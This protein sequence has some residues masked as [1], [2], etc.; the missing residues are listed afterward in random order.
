M[1]SETSAFGLGP[2]KKPT[3]SHP[4]IAFGRHFGR[5]VHAFCRI[6][7]LVD[8]GILLDL[9]MKTRPLNTFT[10]EERQEHRVYRQMLQMQPR[11]EEELISR[12]LEEMH[13]L[14][15]LIQ[16]GCANARADDT[17][18]L[19]GAIVDW[20]APPGEELTPRLARN[21][22]ADRGFHHPRTGALL[23]PVDLDWSD[24]EIKSKLRNQEINTIGDQWPAFLFLD[25]A[26]DPEDP[27]VGLFRGHL[28]VMAYKY[29]F[30]SPSSVDKEPKATKSGN[31]RIHGM[32]QVTP[33][34]IAYV[35]AQVRFALSSTS[36]FS[37]TDRVLDSE[38]FYLSIL[39]LFDDVDERMEVNDLVGWWN[40]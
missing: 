35:A 30:T 18:G 1:A 7:S 10:F 17:K 33:A 6:R 34:S 31:A 24:D 25:Y 37:K 23:C 8:R 32:T 39:E 3:T 5:T 4:L 15:D 12:P 29:I 27:W 22:K 16:K 11:L 26:Y 21:I 13:Q 38:R 40:R 9:E 36:V 28:L 14:C 20:I 2:R 19:K